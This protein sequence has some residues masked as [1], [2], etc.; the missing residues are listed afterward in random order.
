[1]HTLEAWLSVIK[2]SYG[3]KIGSW[4]SSIKHVKRESQGHA[5]IAVPDVARIRAVVRLRRSSG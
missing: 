2:K 4:V 5:L 1:M 3:V